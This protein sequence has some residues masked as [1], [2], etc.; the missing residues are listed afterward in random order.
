[1]LFLSPS[2]GAMRRRVLFA[3]LLIVCGAKLFLAANAPIANAGFEDVA[4]SCTAGPTCHLFGSVTGWTGAGRF[5]TFKPSVGP[6]G[7]YPNGIP[8]GV[9]VAALGDDA[10]SGVLVQTL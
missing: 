4:L 1:M 7:I 3:A 6:D 10:G 2:G 5:Y 9:N 8:E